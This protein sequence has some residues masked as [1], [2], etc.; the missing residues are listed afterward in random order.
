MGE[1]VWGGGGG[2][3]RVLVTGA[4]GFLGRVQVP[5]LVVDGHSIT[6]LGG[7]TRE[8][9]FDEAVEYL[10]LDLTAAESVSAAFS[11][12]RWDALVHLAGPVAHAALDWEGERDLVNSH[13][14]MA[15]NLSAVIP[16]GWQGRVV[17]ASSMTVYGTPQ[18]LPM[19]ESHPRSPRHMYGLG[20]LL[21]EDVWLSKRGV[22]LWCLRFPGLFSANRRGGALYH[23]MQ[24]ARTGRPLH[25]TAPEPTAWDVLDVQDAAEAIR[26]ALRAESRQAGP[27]N[28]S[29]GEAV[30]L[31]GLARMVIEIAESVSPIVVQPDIR[32]PA[33]QMSITKAAALLE[34]SPPALRSRLHDLYI[35]FGEPA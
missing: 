12:W 31:R 8:S 23:F 32:H 29:Y 5:S 3:L 25:I 2:P 10:S 7:A 30:E 1:K 26:L 21:A 19:L 13:V 28:V 4:T 17:H 14:R 20:K 34:W 6:A 11:D 16:S 15:L 22:D 27:L 18:A 9:P 33:F 35:A 24:A